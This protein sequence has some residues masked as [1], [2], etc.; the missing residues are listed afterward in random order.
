MNGGAKSVVSTISLEWIQCARRGSA[1]ST[2][3]RRRRRRKRRRKTC[4]V[5]DSDIVRSEI[6]GN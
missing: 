1:G 5:S 2:E 3:R 4:C 6:T